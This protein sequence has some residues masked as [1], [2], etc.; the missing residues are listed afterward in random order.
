MVPCGWEEG[1]HQEG[2]SEMQSKKPTF[3]FLN[4]LQNLLQWF[5]PDMEVN[6]LLPGKEGWGAKE[7]RD[8]I[9]ERM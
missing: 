4:E 5:T 2:V 8:G 3:A 1:W 6:N 9:E 7:E